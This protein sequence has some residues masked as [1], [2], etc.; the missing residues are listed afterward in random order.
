MSLLFRH[1]ALCWRGRKWDFKAGHSHHSLS[2][3]PSYSWSLSITRLKIPLAPCLPA[4]T[5][6]FMY[7]Q[8]VQ[9]SSFQDANQ[10]VAMQIFQKMKKP[11]EIFPSKWAKLWHLRKAAVQNTQ[12]KLPVLQVLADVRTAA[13][14]TLSIIMHWHAKEMICDS[15]K[16]KG[17]SIAWEDEKKE[18]GANRH[19]TTIG[20]MYPQPQLISTHWMSHNVMTWGGTTRK[21]TH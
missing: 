3:S 20:R 10:C 15:R 11:W 6:P 12:R 4:A 8:N 16:Q 2:S 5:E 21:N 9:L 17:V 19:L 7:V 18:S 14:Q 1:V 13:L